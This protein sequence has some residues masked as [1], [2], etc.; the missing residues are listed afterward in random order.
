LF[1]YLVTVSVIIPNYN[2]APFL[3]RRIESVLYQTYQEFEVIILDDCST[4][5]SREILTKYCNHPKVAKLLFNNENS[6]S[7]F[8][9]WEKGI[10]LAKGEWIWIAESDDWCEPT[11]L[12][13]LVSGIDDNVTM[14]YCGSMAL[15][16]NQVEFIGHGT[17]FEQYWNGLD[18]IKNKMLEGNAVFN[19]SMAIFR[20]ESV[21]VVPSSFN[22]FKYCGDLLFWIAVASQGLVFESARILNYFI[23]HPKDVST[24]ALI[25]GL[26]YSELLPIYNYLLD[27][28]YIEKWRY[29]EL[30]FKKINKIK[31]DNL[32]SNKTKSDLLK[33]Y[34]H[35]L[36][37][38]NYLKI[39]IKNTFNKI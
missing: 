26:A 6:G 14:C 34:F 36:G 38:K 37:K 5:N 10:A 3:E 22:G 19:A 27:S 32:I 11:L 9:Q 4:D 23:K 31:A 25:N 7:T 20:K 8:K 17:A 29:Q 16:N 39:R 15:R 28:K 33:K 21:S 24:N 13:T 35:N 12:E 1:Q 18:F 30:L 2:H